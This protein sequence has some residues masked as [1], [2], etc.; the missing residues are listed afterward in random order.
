[1]CGIFCYVGKNYSEED[2]LEN[3]NR[4]KLRGP[5]SS[6][7]I[8]VDNVLLGFH[9]L[10]INDISE[11]GMQPFISDGLYL[12]CNGEIYNH[13]ELYK[14]F[15]SSSC[16]LKSNSDCEVIIYLYKFFGIERTC[17]LLDGVFSFVLYDSL[18]KIVY[19]ARDPYGVRPLFVGE[20]E[21]N[22]YFFSSEMKAIHDKC[23]NVRQ[24]DTGSYLE[25]TPTKFNIQKYHE[26]KRRNL[27]GR[28]F[29]EEICSYIRNLLINSVEKR[30]LSDRPIGALL[31]GGL[32]S[33]LICGIISKLYKE[34]SIE[35]KLKTFSIGI[36]GSTDL[37]YAQNV[38]DYI[39][40]EHHNIECTEEDFLN[41]I[42]E[43]IYNI[44][45]YDT[46]TVRASVGNYLVGKYIKENTDIV[47]LFN[48]DGS[49]EQSGYKYL[50]NA[51]NY[52]EFQEECLKLLTEI[53]YFDVLRS[54]RSVSSRWS[55]EART[56]FL[57]KEFV[58]FYMGIDPI[59]KMY[60][61]KNKLP[62]KY[63]LR[64]SFENMN[65]IPDE[66]LWRPKEAFSDG[67]SSET[68]SWHKVIQEHVDKIISDEEF[69][70]NKD[71]YK[72]NTPVLKE[73]Y[74]Y[75]KLFNEYYPNKDNVIP[76]F[77]LPKWSKVNDPSA[78]EL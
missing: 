57:D 65:I 53:Q 72:I 19:V 45:S 11:K 54:D 75:R 34:K 10:A 2:L 16:E 48:G 26:L 66:V 17:Q 51:P 5:D 60:N 32:D 33:S 28:N 20:K 42:P 44:E 52:N 56:P 40:S 62:E 15:L 64:K 63:M 14:L 67:C 9:R 58:D 77:W 55:L 76:H 41:A 36:K 29:Q 71:K 1:M 13:K 49:D 47:V 7:L 12:I 38:A 24:F 25:Y 70:N 43:V 22:E 61:S 21:N 35:N 31:S 59:L 73:S 74:W 8:K 37:V 68:R 18:K 6:R 30:L 27:Y 50:R 4:I 3:F 23:T 39:N 78:R 46:T 69:I